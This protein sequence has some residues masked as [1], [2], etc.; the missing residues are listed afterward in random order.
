MNHSSCGHFPAKSLFDQTYTRHKGP[1]EPEK[2]APD[3]KRNR[4]TRKPPGNWWK[5]SD[6]GD[7]DADPPS[8]PQPPLPPPQPQSQKARKGA[9][10]QAKRRK[11]LTPVA[12]KTITAQPLSTPPGVTAIPSSAGSTPYKRN[13]MFA[14]PK[15]IKRSLAMF[16][17]IFNRTVEVSPPDAVQNAAREEPT[18]RK[19]RLLA[20]LREQYTGGED[21]V[22][23]S[24]DLQET[25]VV[26]APADGSS[27]RPSW[28]SSIAPPQCN[29]RLSDSM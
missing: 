14:A 8:P 15:T 7:A 4:R 29:K 20:P 27:R 3:A 6:A 5:T 2:G 28:P 17:D 18:G 22:D 25:W 23:M 1:P 12:A 10:R 21:D 9:K 16:Q 11:S 24:D 19:K 13:T 26:E